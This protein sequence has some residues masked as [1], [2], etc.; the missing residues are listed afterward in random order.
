ML[1]RNNIYMIYNTSSIKD[2]SILLE[3]HNKMLNGVYKVVLQSS[4]L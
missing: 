3:Y 4:T 2:L 1:D